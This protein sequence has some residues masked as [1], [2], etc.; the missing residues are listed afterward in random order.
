[1]KNSK[2]WGLLISWIPVLHVYTIKTPLIGRISIKT[3]FLG[4]KN[5]P[6]IGVPV[7]RFFLISGQYVTNYATVSPIVSETWKP[8]N[9]ILVNFPVRRKR[10]QKTAKELLGLGLRLIIHNLHIGRYLKKICHSGIH[11]WLIGQYLKKICHG[12]IH[13]WQIGQYLKKYAMVASI[14]GKLDNIWKHLPWWH[15]L[16]PYW[17]IFEKICHGGIHRWHIGR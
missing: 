3:V 11:C 10:L 5:C 14:V 4:P 16:L 12:G 17:M 13:P 2:K 1:M 15:P 9:V 6:I 8:N 7:L